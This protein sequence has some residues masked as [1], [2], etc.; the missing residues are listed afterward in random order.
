MSLPTPEQVT[1]WLR[2][3]LSVIAPR[4][5]ES[6]H[7]E[8]LCRAYLTLHAER[9]ELR[10]EKAENISEGRRYLRGLR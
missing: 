8:E 6:E 5:G 1:A 7:F 2:H 10:R 9:D 3:H 4:P